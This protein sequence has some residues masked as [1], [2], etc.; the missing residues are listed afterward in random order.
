MNGKYNPA[1]DAVDFRTKTGGTYTV[2]ENRVDFSDIQ[3]KS[4]EIQE[5]IR[6]LASKGIIMG[7]D[8]TRRTFSPD[9]SITRAETAALIVRALAKLDPN[10]DGRFTDVKRNDWYFGAAGSSKKHGIIKGYENNTFRGTLSIPKDQVITVAAR[11]L[12]TE[13]N[14]HY[15]TNITSVLSV[16]SD[17]GGI[18][19]WAAQGAALATKE[20]LLPRRADGTFAPKTNITRGEAAIIIKRMFDKIW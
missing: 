15:P 4:G 12:V 18:E 19:P 1:T 2:K 9:A 11:T 3:A 17:N 20:N 5:A 14:F 13:M 16:Y 8:K 6:V 10:E 7:T